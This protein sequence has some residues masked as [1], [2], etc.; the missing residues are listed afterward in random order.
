MNNLRIGLVVPAHNPL[1]SPP[2]KIWAPGM[3]VFNLA[4]KLS[5]LGHRVFLFAADDSKSESLKINFIKTGINSLYHDFPHLRDE[6]FPKFS[7][8]FAIYDLAIVSKAIEFANNNQLDILHFH[9]LRRPLFLLS[10]IKKPTLF[11]YHNNLSPLYHFWL[12]SAAKRFGDKIYLTALSEKHS[13]QFKKYFR[14]VQ[15]IHNGIEIDKFKYHHRT[16]KNFLFVGRMIKDKGVKNAIEIALKTGIKLDLIGHAG[17]TEEDKKYFQEILKRIKKTRN[18]RYLGYVTHE[19]MSGKYADAK[20]LLFPLEWDEPFGLSMVEAMASGV[21]VI[22]YDTGSVG[23]LVINNKTGFVIPKGNQL[24]M[25]KA[26]NLLQKMP[27]ENYLKMK[28]NCRRHVEEN[29]SLDKMVI[30]YEK[31]YYKIIRKMKD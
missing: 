7:E 29:Y 15:V 10:L 23:E 22:A 1:P 27:K 28:K 19:E 21:P 20:A 3:V 18:I 17:D 24:E 12:K 13:L 5:T 14:N 9:D 16:G 25:I 4:K 11:T 8:L 31:V 30:E 2:D 26:I 6:D